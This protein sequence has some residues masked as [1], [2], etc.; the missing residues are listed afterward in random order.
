M[1]NSLLTREW[2][3][4]MDRQD[5]LAR[6]R[7]EFYVQEG[8][9]YLN[10]NSLGLM[11][12]RAEASLFT[13]MESWKHYGID[14][15]TQGKRPWFFLAEQLRVRL[16][17]LIGAEEHEVIVT[18]STTVNIH[19]LV[20][21]FY[22]PQGNRTKIVADALNFPSD[23][24]ALQSQL[25]LSGFD[26]DT[27]LIRIP[28]ADGR[29]LDEGEIA[30]HLTE[31]V[32]LVLLPTVLYGSGQRLDVEGL[33]NL[34]HERGIV[35]GWDACHSIGA[36]PHQFHKWGVDFA[37]W[38]SYKYV[39]GGPGGVGGLF[40][41][42]KHLPATPG[43]AG[44]FGSDKQRQFDMTHTF[45]P[46]EDAGAFQIGTPHVLS[47]APLVGS[48]EMFGEAG[49]ER[50]R[51]KSLRLTQYLMDL[52]DTELAGMGFQIG[53]PRAD[54]QRGGHVSLIHEEA[55]RICKALKGEGVVPDYR[56]PDVIRLAP[57]ALYTSFVEVWE[58][59]KRLKRIMTDKIYEQYSNERG[60]VA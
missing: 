60:V 53:N 43:L 50:I 9:I 37:V 16:A 33:T 20:A 17:P 15:W 49:I 32:A 10:G 56:A 5:E 1:H 26:P 39:N 51:A 40:V 30:R 58:A 45:V 19:Q 52:V 41:H 12:K 46:A 42:E 18:G 36:M 44:W 38:C 11:S 2:A 24:Y 7:Q 29:C 59:I 31:E 22:Q 21:T 55:V 3:E 4:E 48:L 25:R 47:M 28:S 13:L 57:V 35:V 34:A 54:E 8:T 14:G 6:F 27:H 23:I